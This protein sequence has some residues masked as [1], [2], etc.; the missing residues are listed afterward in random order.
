MSPK[1]IDHIGIAVRSLEQSVPL[2]RDVL[3]LKFLGY[4]TVESEQVRVA[5][6]EIGESRIE[7]LEPLSPDSPIAGYMEKKG[8]GIHH[9]A[10]RVDGIE[11]ELDRLSASGF[12]L[13]HERPKVGAHGSRVAFVHPKSTLGVLY[14]L[15]QPED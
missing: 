10:L 4:E 6:M 3:G 13:I 12:R 8:E 7:L 1:R 14:E 9:I 5:F 15:C 2:Y 11:Q